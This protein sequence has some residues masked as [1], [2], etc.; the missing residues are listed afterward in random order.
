MANGEVCIKLVPYSVNHKHTNFD[1][2]TS[3]LRAQVGGCT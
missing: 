1:K 2:H 3:L